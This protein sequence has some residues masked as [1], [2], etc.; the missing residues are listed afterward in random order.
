MGAASALLETEINRPQEEVRRGMPTWSPAHKMATL[1][2]PF[3]DVE[4]I[5]ASKDEGAAPPFMN[6]PEH[7][8]S[9]YNSHYGI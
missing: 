5:F 9:N 1:N 8:T 7:S 4:G 2:L 3:P 6:H